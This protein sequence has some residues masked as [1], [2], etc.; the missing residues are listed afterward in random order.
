VRFRAVGGS[1]SA[2]ARGAALVSTDALVLA[3]A[4]LI[5]GL[6]T[7][8]QLVHPPRPDLALCYQAA[9]C[10][11]VLPREHTLVAVNVSILSSTGVPAGD[12]LRRAVETLHESH[13]EQGGDQEEELHSGR[14][15]GRN[16]TVHFFEASAC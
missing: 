12:A 14:E 10:P 8:L 6:Q 16:E 3:V 1:G 4:V 13:R 9:Q 15:W 2:A 5:L 7:A 11:A